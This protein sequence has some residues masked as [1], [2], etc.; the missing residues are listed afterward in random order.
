[1][2]SYVCSGGGISFCC[3]PSFLKL[4]FQKLN[5]LLCRPHFLCPALF[6]LE[7][8]IFFGFLQVGDEKGTLAVFPSMLAQLV[9]SDR[10]AQLVIS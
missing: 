2:I 9:S 4:H 1:M 5:S 6:L 7:V 3:S 10:F 8:F